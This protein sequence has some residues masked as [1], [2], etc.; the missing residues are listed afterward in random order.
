MGPNALFSFI[1]SSK[2]KSLHH[3]PDFGALPPAV[4]RDYVGAVGRRAGASFFARHLDYFIVTLNF[5]AVYLVVTLN[6]TAVYLD[7]LP[8]RSVT[9]TRSSRPSTRTGKK[10]GTATQTAP[11]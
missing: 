5:T 3:L 10:R 8:F 9:V 11:N 1:R 4:Y 7:L 2:R 6:F